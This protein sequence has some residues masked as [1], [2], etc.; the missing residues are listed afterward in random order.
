MTSTND[1]TP[2][3]QIQWIDQHGQPTPDTNPSIGR[4]RTKDRFSQVTPTRCVHMS[5]SQWFHICAEHAKQ[6]HKPGMEIWESESPADLSPFNK[7]VA[8][9]PDKPS[10]PEPAVKLSGAEPVPPCHPDF[11]VR[12]DMFG[13]YVCTLAEAEH[14]DAGNASAGF[15]GRPHFAT[16]AEA[17]QA[18]ADTE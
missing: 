15:D 9:E 7:P 17:W 18:I 4:V 3:C 8:P 16:E 13:F 5:A 2:T 1:K 10:A 11:E 14:E 6:M 12:H